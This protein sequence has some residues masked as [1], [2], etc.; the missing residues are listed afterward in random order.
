MD[1]KVAIVNKYGQRHML[2]VKL[3]IVAWVVSGVPVETGL[4][5]YRSTK[6]SSKAVVRNNLVQDS[7][8]WS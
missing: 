6:T 7:S 1:C 4:G 5:K 8:K 2:N 3:T